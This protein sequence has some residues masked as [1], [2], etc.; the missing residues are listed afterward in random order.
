MVPDSQYIIPANMKRNLA[1]SAPSSSREAAAQSLVFGLF[2]S[3]RFQFYFAIDKYAE[4]MHY[5]SI[6]IEYF[7]RNVF[8]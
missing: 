4:N 1:L 5:Y 7:T 2:P 3:E 6:L 8:V